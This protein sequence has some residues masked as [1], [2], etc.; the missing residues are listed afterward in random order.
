MKKSV[1]LSFLLLAFMYGYSQ[2]TL[3]DSAVYYD[4]VF[5]FVQH[6]PIFPGNVDKWMADNMIYPEEASNKNIQGTVYLNIVIEKDGSVSEVKVLKGID[7]GSSL[8]SEAVRAAS[9]MPKWSSGIMNGHSVKVAITLPVNFKL[10]E[11]ADTLKGKWYT[12]SD[13]KVKPVFP[14]DFLKWIEK[15]TPY[16]KVIMHKYE[17]DTVYV[18][19]VVEADGSTSHINV[20]KGVDNNYL[21]REA[22]WVVSKMPKWVPGKQNGKAVRV[23]C[24]API[25][26]ILEPGAKFD[27][28]EKPQNSLAKTIDTTYTAYHIRII[29]EK[30]AF[31]GDL[32]KWLMEHL[33]YPKMARDAN[34]QGTVYLSF[35]VEKDGHITSV[36]ILRGINLYLNEEALNVVSSMPNWKPGKINGKEV[37]VQYMLPVRFILR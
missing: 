17:Y 13:V 16:P 22:K 14:D 27:I 21:N 29:Q 23:L 36:R 18:S 10:L 35:I 15:N 4:Q 8:D 26:Y 3:T 24:V 32:N 5:H 37:R 31:S 20:L 19:F 30:P 12:Y 25:S 2:S 28:D 9:S 33:E 11:D 6:K 1:L 7:S 34:I